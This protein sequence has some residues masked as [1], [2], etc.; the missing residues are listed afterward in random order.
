MGRVI[1]VTNQKGGVGKTTTTVNLAASLA[2][3]DRK[4]LI[5]DLDPQGN[6]SS[7]LG[8]D[9]TSFTDKNL[10]HALIGQVPMSQV[11]KPTE[12]DSLFVAPSNND[13][14]GAE[15]ELVSAFARENK[16]K[17]ALLD[18]RDKYD[19]IFIDCPP[20]LGLLTVNALTAADS[21]LVPLQCEYFALEGLSQ[22]L[23]TVSLIR[24]SLNPGLQ[25]EGIVLT[26]YD[27][28]N[29][30]SNEVVREVRTH[31]GGKVFETVI[32]RN[33]RLSECS[34][35]GKPILLYDIDSKGSI[36]YLNL[37]KEIITKSLGAIR[38]P[39]MNETAS[40]VEA[41]DTPETSETVPPEQRVPTP[42]PFN[43]PLSP[44]SF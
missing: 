11:V 43:K 20:S 6:A 2:V 40:A 39:V 22:L 26:M 19:Y 7:A 42:P 37:A 31:F 24:Q 1:A 17:A 18:L 33:V 4:T 23:H 41:Y 13:L 44:E 9:K 28:R 25:D 21:F 34:S 30:L 10:Y 12:I 15:I 36:A 14:T 8:L 38:A 35:F 5:L 29:N 3:A 16:L 32:P 27:G